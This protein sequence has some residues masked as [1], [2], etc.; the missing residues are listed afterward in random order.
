VPLLPGHPV[1]PAPA[2]RL[3]SL[4]SA[5]CALLAVHAVAIPL[6]LRAGFQTPRDGTIVGHVERFAHR[7]QTDDS[8]RPMEAA[9]AYARAHPGDD[10]YEEIF[11]RR[12]LKFQY[13]PS[14]LLFIAGLPRDVLNLVSWGC[15]WITVAFTVALFRGA[16][17][18]GKSTFH[19]AGTFDLLV[20]LLAVAGLCL[21]FYP[22]IKG[23]TLGQIQVWV[24]ALLAAALWAWY[25]GRPVASGICLGI[26]C[27]IK[28]PLF[29]L[30]LWAL[31]RRQRAMLAGMLA[32]CCIGVSISI[33]G[34]GF[35]SHVTYLRVL[36]YI[37]Q[38]GEAYYPNQ[39]VN[40]LLNRWLGNGDNLEFQ[41]FEFA[42][43]NAI[44]SRAT[45][46][47]AIVL[48]LLAL[49]VPARRHRDDP[50]FDLPL[51]AATAT[52]ISPIAWEHHYGVWPPIL[53]LL[54]PALLDL[55]GARWQVAAALCIAFLLTAQYFSPVQRL[56]DTAW[57]PLQ[58]YVFFGALL[59]IAT[60]YGVMVRAPDRVPGTVARRTVP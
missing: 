20:R 56:A 47:A 52:I 43:P 57:N 24:D 16:T 28:P 38:R 59:L 39:S 37:G 9:R 46:T 22:L 25:A 10:I 31:L 51:M 42:P 21:S 40:G 41:K 54:V 14:S 19:Q 49:I 8:W 17:Q 35:A 29:V 45:I 27:L 55:T 2:L 4:T 11:F 5:L 3:S 1:P 60:A 18:T 12:R 58:S 7:Q 13:P 23:Y 26:A 53:A 50:R 6:A 33:A 30:A 34:Y 48:L 15:V 32:T 36:S 44:V